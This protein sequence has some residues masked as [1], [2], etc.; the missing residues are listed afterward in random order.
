V[1]A[2]LLPGAI[3]TCLYL[4]V[5]G[6]AVTLATR[7]TVD[8]SIF[9][10]FAVA[11][12]CG[13]AAVGAI[14]FV[15]A[16]L[17]VLAPLP[18]AVT[19][20]VG[21]A[22]AFV[23][24]G[25]RDAFHAHIAAWRGDLRRRPW[26]SVTAAIVIVGTGVA[27]WL[28][29]P[30][31][32]IGP[33]VPRY[34]ADA[35]EIAD[36]GGI[37]QGTLQWGTVLP[38]TTS[39]VVLNAFDAG[40]SMLIGRD[41]VGSQAVLRYVV[42]IGLIVVAIG[43][44]RELGIRRLAPLGAVLL[45]ADPFLPY[46]LTT[47][48]GRNVAEN[49]G[50]LASF[51]AV[52]AWSLALPVAI[53]ERPPNDIRPRIRAGPIV[54]GGLVLAVAAGT[55]LVA[56]AF[57]IAA[58]SSLALSSLVV[59]RWRRV[60]PV[61]AGGIVGLALLTGGLILAATPGDLGF[62]GVGS[63]DPYRDL[64]SSLGL[65]PSFDP[66]RFI[67]THDVETASH[68]EPLDAA[69]VAEEFAYKVSGSSA[70]GVVPGEERP[71]WALFLPSIVALLLVGVAVTL[72]PAPLRAAA[73]AAP[74]LGLALFLV[75]LIFALRYD[76][77]VLQ[78]VGSRRLFSYAIVPFVLALTAAGE[79]VAAR[80]ERGRA[81]RAT[82]VA[83]VLLITAT[84]VGSIVRVDR[85][86]T[87]AEPWL[88]QLELVGWVGRHV[89]C[90]GVVL[91]DRRTLG[92]FQVVAGHAAVL[93]GMGPHLRPEVLE[94]A[95]GEIFRARDFFDDPEDGAAYLRERSV[96]AIVVTRRNTRIGM[97]GYPITGLQKNRL[98]RV[99]FLTP[100]FTNDAGW[101]FLVD[102]FAPDPSTPRVTGRPG[103][104]CHAP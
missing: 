68:M 58:I 71:W 34:W 72:G 40:V 3:L 27:G 56:A 89:P 11:F 19:W 39:K 17:G 48:L 94:L 85:K 73:L 57:G 12:P 26:D 51:G 84:L 88:A 90:E 30:A 38:P 45:F 100:A 66:T 101:I 87:S 49:W 31:S 103:F 43:L 8:R 25:R 10:F 5:P 77:F 47:D 99:P 74:I 16:L 9:T 79:A 64:R 13:F 55:H 95:I 35:L 41:L 83:V 81:R 24:A 42:T 21:T 76:E 97:L 53:D 69:G 36:V 63:G 22:V 102:G 52:L 14:S 20:L 59:P 67:V 37:P 82:S 2:D 1:S 80:L 18:V 65:P 70:L 29:P 86:E 75:G 50:R 33:T 46:D 28:V 78:S 96:A 104:D 91:A 62:G 92:T 6:A 4:V 7:I 32:A 23:I 44:L 61:A 60:A 54:V 98:E 93:E 15:L